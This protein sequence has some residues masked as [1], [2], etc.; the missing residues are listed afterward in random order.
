MSAQEKEPVNF[1]E[2][3]V[4]SLFNDMA[5]E[6]DDL[7][8]EWY[9]H[10][11]HQ[12]E[13]VIHS[14]FRHGEGRR[15]IDVGCGTG[16]QTFTLQSLGY[17]TYGIDIAEE[18]LKCAL[19]KARR[20]GEPVKLAMASALALPFPDQSF[21][22]VNCCG[23]TLSFISEYQRALGEMARV[24]KEGGH[25]I[26]EVEFK[27]NL[28]LFWP[29]V[30]VLVGGRLGYEQSWQESWRNLTGPCRQGIIISYPFTRL[31]GSI[32]YLPLRCFSLTELRGACAP[33]GLKLCRIYG[34]HSIT[35]L[36]PS[37]W[38][39]SPNLRSS[40]RHMVRSCAAIEDKLKGFFPFDRLGCSM[41]LILRKEDECLV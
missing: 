33:L 30:D 14:H 40:F 36:F 28:D 7:E 12:I 18:L 4:A 35:N 21:D 11:F 27:W 22:L 6:Y 20:K 31:D 17:E 16:I 37:P 15:A 25:V 34:V 2:K 39:H 13:K 3:H 32:D 10:L 38:L 9:P 23:S 26:I 8:D 41:I 1:D 19:A 29:L 5:D 24:V